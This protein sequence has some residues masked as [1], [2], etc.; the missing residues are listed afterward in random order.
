MVVEGPGQP[1]VIACGGS[2]VLPA[3][4]RM[5]TYINYPETRRHPA[6]H[7]HL[8]DRYVGALCRRLSRESLV[9][10]VSQARGNFHECRVMTKC[11]VGVGCTPLSGTP[12]QLGCSKRIKCLGSQRIK[13]HGHAT[14]ITT[15][16]LSK[17]ASEDEVHETRT[18]EDKTATV[19]PETHLL[20]SEHKCRLTSPHVA[21]RGMAEPSPSAALP[22]PRE[23][24]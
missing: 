20:S 11:S 12:H 7:W 10:A 2:S 1:F 4:S 5:H 15:K 8:E 6:L 21:L 22:A 23:S 17:D 18:E 9:L 19:S 3:K 16:I 14:F 13:C 24:C